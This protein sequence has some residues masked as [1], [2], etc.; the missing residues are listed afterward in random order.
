MFLNIAKCVSVLC[1]VT[2]LSA[3]V[4]AE[5]LKYGGI[6]QDVIIE[7]TDLGDGRI[8]KKIIVDVGNSEWDTMSGGFAPVGGA[9][10]NP[11]LGVWPSE[12]SAAANQTTLY[13]FGPMSL[14][15][16]GSVEGVV[17]GA[18]ASFDGITG[19]QAIGQLVIEPASP[20]H[21]FVTL[22]N[23]GEPSDFAFSSEDGGDRGAL[24]LARGGSPVG[25]IEGSSVV[26]EPSTFVLLLLGSI[27][28]LVA[29]RRR[30]S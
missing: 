6:V 27:A 18:T 11:M 23:V 14:E 24:K 7:D 25:W 29:W 17:T 3:P 12:A 26:P 9:F 28:G 10:S 20:K 2:L 13:S 4:C 15:N 8:K 22:D 30:R 19:R 1:V 21:G 16:E 5:P